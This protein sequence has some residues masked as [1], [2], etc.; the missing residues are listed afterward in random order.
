MRKTHQGA[1]GKLRSPQRGA[2]SRLLLYLQQR[3][4]FSQR[5]LVIGGEQL[6]YLRVT[7]RGRVH[8]H[9]ELTEEREGGV[10]QARRELGQQRGVLRAAAP[11]KGERERL[12]RALDDLEQQLRLAF[13][14]AV[15]RAGRNAAPLG[16]RR[17]RGAGKA[18]LGEQLRRR[19]QDALPCRFARDRFAA[20]PLTRGDGP[21]RAGSGLR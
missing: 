17:H 14:M 15:D 13:E 21:Q 10:G 8:F 6:A 19:A 3:A 1:R 2:G 16:N 5:H 4:D 9:G 20:G 18:M 11:L 7:T 12:Q